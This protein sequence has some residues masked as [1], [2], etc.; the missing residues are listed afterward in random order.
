M[1]RSVPLVAAVA[2]ALALTG[3]GADAASD[4]DRAALAE[5][6]ANSFAARTD[7]D[8]L[9]ER[10]ARTCMEKQGFMVHPTPPAESG[11]V[12]KPYQSPNIEVAME[13]RHIVREDRLA[14]IG[15][16][17]SPREMLGF[18]PNAGAGTPRSAFDRLS[19]DEQDRYWTAYQG[20]APDEVD[21]TVARDGDDTPVKLPNHEIFTLPDGAQV[22]YPTK[23]CVAETQ[24][25]IFDGKLREFTELGHYARDGIGKAAIGDV[26]TDPA[27]RAKD[28]EWASCMQTKGFD[29]LTEPTEARNRASSSYGAEIFGPDSP[30]FAEKKK[31]EIAIATADVA[32]NHQVQLDEARVSIFWRN[33]ARFYTDRETQVA[34]WS[35]LVTAARARAQQMLAG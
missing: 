19:A 13:A 18:D 26:R 23:G 7:L 28:A 4:A 21:S 6:L 1:N 14:E 27:V 2:V 16:G 35:D 24:Q 30:G 34:A 22:S 29:G 10:L 9:T 3:C 25:R 15:Y 11:E 31:Q 32:C 8:K 17:L 5:T 12:M 20:Y 33:V